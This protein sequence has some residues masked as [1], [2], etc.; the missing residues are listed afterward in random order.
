MLKKCVFRQFLH[1]CYRINYDVDFF[2]CSFWSSFK[3]Y[4][5][6]I[7]YTF[8]IIEKGIYP[9]VNLALKVACNSNIFNNL[10]IKYVQIKVLCYVRNIS[11]EMSPISRSY[12]L[13]K[14]VKFYNNFNIFLDF[15]EF[16]WTRLILSKIIAEFSQTNYIYSFLLIIYIKKTLIPLYM[17]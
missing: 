16:G 8:W 11:S 10:Q 14:H 9:L 5:D 2:Y 6:L 15:V 4:W 1:F 13:E 17:C 12:A 7:I 3:K